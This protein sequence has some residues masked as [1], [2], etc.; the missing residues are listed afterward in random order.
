[1]SLKKQTFSG[2][3]WT[4][5]DTLI[6]KGLFFAATILLARILGPADFGLIGLISVFLALGVSIVDSG[7]SSSLI[8]TVNV[9]NKDYSTV[10]Y[11]NLLMGVFIY[12]VLFFLAPYIAAFYDQP[13]L[14]N[15]IRVYCLTFIVSGFSS[16][17]L[18]I[19]NKQMR[20]L[21]M[22]Y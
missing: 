11:L 1:M 4:I 17:Q 18:A 12:G 22:S 13:I 14:I 7:L 16:V 3:V 2:L 9:E 8:R 15:I 21:C 10:F 5:A 20:F 6:L 19:L